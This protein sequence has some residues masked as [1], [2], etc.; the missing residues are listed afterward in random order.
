MIAKGD[1]KACGSKKDK[2]QNY[3]EPIDAEV[4]EIDRDRGDTEDESSDKERA[5]RPIKAM[6]W[7]AGKHDALASPARTLLPAI[8][9]PGQRLFLSSYELAGNEGRR[10]WAFSL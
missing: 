3:L 6:K 2:K 9:A 8:S 5:S 1:A 7:N 4:P 10:T